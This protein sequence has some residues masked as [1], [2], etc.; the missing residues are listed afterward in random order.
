M[1]QGMTLPEI[2]AMD[3]EFY[4]ELLQGTAKRQQQEKKVYIDQIL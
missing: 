4:F 1:K 3:F 2:D